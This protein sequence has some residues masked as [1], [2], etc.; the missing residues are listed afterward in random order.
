MNAI[1]V[2][3][4]SSLQPFYE[5]MK[6]LRKPLQLERIGFS[7]AQYRYFQQ[8][9]ER[10]P[11]IE[12][13]K[14]YLLKEW[15]ITGR[16]RDGQ[17]DLDIIGQYERKLGVPHLWGPLVADRRVFLGRN[18]TFVQD[19][20]PRFSHDEMLNI[21]QWGLVEMERLFDEVQP[22][23]AISF[24]CV[25]F[26][27]Y[28]AYLFAR[29]RGIPFLNLRHTRIKNYMTCGEGIFEPSERIRAAYYRYR[30][31]AIDDGWMAQA[32][33]HIDLVGSG[34][35]SFEQSERP[36]RRAS[37]VP[38]PNARQTF[39]RRIRLPV[40]ILRALRAEYDYR[41]GEIQ[42][43]HNPGVLVPLIYKTFLR[44]VRIRWNHQ[45]LSHHY[46]TEDELGSLNYAFFPLNTEPEVSMLVHSKPYLN[47]IDVIRNVS[48]NIPVGMKLVVKEHPSSVGKRPLSY[49]QKLLDIPNVRLADPK[50]PAGLLVDNSRLVATIQGSV[51]WEAILRKK[52]VVIFGQATYEFLP[53]SMLRRVRD[54]ENLGNEVA[55][56]M[57][58]YEYQEEAVTA[59]VAAAMSQS[60]PIDFYSTL[61]GR[62]GRYGTGED[63]F[64]R[65]R[66]MHG[67]TDLLAQYII[68][69]LEDQTRALARR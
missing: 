69:A 37:D 57:Q 39:Y 40:R 20:R 49:Y 9:S 1:F 33:N 17:P 38:S 47:Q 58:N 66:A 26:E 14:Y 5:L 31:G 63:M 4:G 67:D 46:V 18:S 59:F 64:A 45:R 15:E 56:L 12:S 13:G 16:A 54:L 48:S 32:R 11:D 22:A 52:P 7:V 10:F 44:R 60:V 35:E 43:N 21:L 19:Y 27:E 23:F 24:I 53:S 30:D 51:G 28:L 3:Q 50:L 62:W 2:T 61:L 36:A 34:L 25:T 55:D 6:A 8:F 29:S 41:F 42:D 65:Q 68:E